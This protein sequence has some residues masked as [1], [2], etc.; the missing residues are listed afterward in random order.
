M[1]KFS[2]SDWEIILAVTHA[3]MTA[4]AFQQLV[5]QWLARARDP[6]FHQPY[7]ALVYQP[8]LEVM[9]YL[10]ANTMLQRFVRAA[11]LVKRCVSSRGKPLEKTERR[12]AQAKLKELDVK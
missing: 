10:R 8:M 5:K 3:G 12:R 6:R 2:E 4:E 11:D 1:A 7:T 9:D